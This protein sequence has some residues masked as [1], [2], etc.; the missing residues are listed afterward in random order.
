MKSNCY[1]RTKPGNLILVVKIEADQERCKNVT[2]I[3]H[4]KHPIRK[5][6]FE[7]ILERV[8][9]IKYLGYAISHDRNGDG[10]NT[11]N[12]LIFAEFSVM[13]HYTLLV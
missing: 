11:I 1:K 9:I 6:Q 12:S 4:G 8:K 7:N 5:I 10:K 3:F 2:M 13:C